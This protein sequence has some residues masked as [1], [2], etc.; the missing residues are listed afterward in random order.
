MHKGF[1]KRYP[2]ALLHDMEF[3]QGS[4]GRKSWALK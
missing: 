4:D 2:K 1:W 3:M